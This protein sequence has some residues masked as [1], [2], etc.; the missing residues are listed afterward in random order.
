MWWSFPRPSSVEEKS[1]AAQIFHRDLDDFKFAKF[2]IYLT[3]VEQDDGP[4]V[5]VKKSHKPNFKD[6]LRD[7]FLIHRV[8]DKNISKRFKESDVAEIHG[9]AGT[10]FFEDTYGYHKG[11]PPTK[12]ARLLMCIVM[13]TIDYKVQYFQHQ[14]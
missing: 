11:M 6:T 5:Y 12:K 13:A 8:E 7:K 14:V 3:D 9:K 10:I 2:F 1:K 4:H